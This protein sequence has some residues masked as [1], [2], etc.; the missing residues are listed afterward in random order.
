MATAGRQ[1]YPFLGSPNPNEVLL[2]GNVTIG[3]DGAVSDQTDAA[4]SGF[5]VTKTAATDGRYTVTFAATYKQ[6]KAGICR[7]SG[8]ASAAFPTT[9]GTKP[10]FRGKPSESTATVQFTRSDTK[11]D[12]N[13]AS[14]A[15]LHLVFVLQK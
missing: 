10:Q 1:L 9:T 2:S 12:A 13:P 8:P 14:G 3:D 6:Y 15:V 11:A 4:D 5:T 7:M